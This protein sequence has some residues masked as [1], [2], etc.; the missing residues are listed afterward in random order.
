MFFVLA[1]VLT[2]RA[3]QQV[4]VSAATA[5]DKS[6]RRPQA[7]PQSRLHNPNIPPDAKTFPCKDC[8]QDIAVIPAE[9]GLAA[10]LEAHIN[11]RDRVAYRQRVYAGYPKRRDKGRR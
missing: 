9:H 1:T 3:L 8:G 6:M 2:A 7:C 10:K 5:Y 11:P 4:V